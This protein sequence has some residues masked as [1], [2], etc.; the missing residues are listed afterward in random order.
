MR[1]RIGAQPLLTLRATGDE[2][3]CPVQVMRRWTAVL[4]HLPHGSAPVL[5]EHHLTRDA[6]THQAAL[7]PDHRDFPVLTGFDWRGTP[8]ALPGRLAALTPGHLASLAAA[9]HRGHAPTRRRP[10]PPVAAKPQTADLEPDIQLD[11][12]YYERGI[13][14]RHRAHALDADLD[15]LFARLDRETDELLARSADLDYPHQP[16]GQSIPPD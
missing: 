1:H 4:I 8:L 6:P 12:G 16:S 5:L 3:R 10:K 15:E 11:P 9:H 13:A 7:H 14:A 2:H